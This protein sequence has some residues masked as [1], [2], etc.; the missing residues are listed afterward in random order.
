[1]KRFNIWINNAKIC[2]FGR[3]R[4]IWQ[5][6]FASDFGV[7]AAVRNSEWEVYAHRDASYCLREHRKPDLRR[8]S[9]IV[10]AASGRLCLHRY[11]NLKA[12][13]F[14]NPQCRYILF[15]RQCTQT[16]EED[17][18]LKSKVQEPKRKALI[19]RINI[20]GRGL[21]KS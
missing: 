12:N 10:C 6:R 18:A 16:S 17:A 14:N 15:S 3:V 2:R 8:T 13:T 20:G 7:V 5:K 11:L 9:V 4:G 21:R 1:M 19:D